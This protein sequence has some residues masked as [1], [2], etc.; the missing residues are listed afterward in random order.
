MTDKEVEFSQKFGNRELS[1]FLENLAQKIGEGEVGMTFKGRDEIEIKPQ[2]SNR[3]ELE[4]ED[5]EDY[6][7]LEVKVELHEDLGTDEAGREKIKV[8]V[9]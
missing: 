3:V 9:N 5:H 8:K 6:R 1:N 4:F 2:G 7:E